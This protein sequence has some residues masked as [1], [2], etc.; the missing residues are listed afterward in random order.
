MWYP[1]IPDETLCLNEDS[2]PQLN[3]YTTAYEPLFW[4]HFGGPGGM[5][6]AQITGVSASYDEGSIFEFHYGFGEDLTLRSMGLHCGSSERPEFS[7]DGP[8]GER[9]VDIVIAY[10]GVAPKG[11]VLWCEVCPASCRSPARPRLLTFF[12]LSAF[13]EPQQDVAVSLS[14]PRRQS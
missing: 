9:V 12:L 11:K 2:F 3:L 1:D 8:G 4:C 7:I 6:L 5:Y 14:K 10:Q 13:D